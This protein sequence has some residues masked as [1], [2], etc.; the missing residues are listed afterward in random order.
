MQEAAE[1][2]REHHETDVVTGEVD[3]GGAEPAASAT[4]V[5][6]GSVPVDVAPRATTIRVGDAFSAS[7][8]G[9]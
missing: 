2:L 4:A 1:L 5:R 9:W 7:M 8:S 3:H 6:F